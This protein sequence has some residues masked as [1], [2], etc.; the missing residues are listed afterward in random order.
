VADQNQTTNNSTSTG[1]PWDEPLDIPEET[2]KKEIVGSLEDN[3]APVANDSTTET[4]PVPFN[5]PEGVDEEKVGKKIPAEELTDKDKLVMPSQSVDSKPLDTKQN[6]DDSP[7]PTAVDP[8]GQPVD[9]GVI[10]RSEATKQSE[11]KIA[12]PDGLA[13]TNQGTPAQ[14]PAVDNIIKTSQ[15]IVET[16]PATPKDQSPASVS[17]IDKIKQNIATMP[18]LDQPTDSVKPADPETPTIEG[19]ANPTGLPTGEVRNKKQSIFS[20]IN[21][22]K[23]GKKQP[24]IPEAKSASTAPATPVVPTSQAPAT[25]PKTRKPI[26]IDFYKKPGFIGTVSVILIFIAVTFLTENGLVS[27]GFENVYGIVGLEK[28]WGGLPRSPESA[29]AHAFVNGQNNLEFKAKGEITM[30]VDKTINSP[31]TSPLVTVTDF[32]YLARDTEMGPRTKAILAQSNYYYNDDYYEYDNSDS[33]SSDSSSDTSSDS[34]SSST[35]DTTSSIYDTSSQEDYQSYS[36]DSSTIKEINAD[37][38]SLSSADGTKTDFTINKI[39]GKNSSISMI[40]NQNDL[41][42]NSSSDIKFNE[43]AEN[44]KWLDYSLTAL[45][46]KNVVND[47]FSL[48][49]DSGFSIIGRRI[50]NEK[51]GDQRCFRYQ[52]DSLEVSSSLEFLGIESEMVQKI[53]GDVWIGIK[54]KLIHKIDV[55]IIPSISSSA[56]R[57]DLEVE[58]YDYGSSNNIEIPRLDNKIAVTAGGELEESEGATAKEEAVEEEVT[59]TESS[60]DILRK[61][62]LASIKS[63]LLEYSSD[64]GYYPVSSSWS[65]INQA[66]SQVASKLVPEYLAS[67][68]TDPKSAEG[69]Y[70]GYKS[71]GKTFTLSARFENLN[72]SEISQ[73]GDIWLHYVYSSK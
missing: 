24:A 69:F 44:N 1:S 9:S 48:K 38:E 67:I 39:T 16:P 54:D 5:I 40:T 46:S 65:N 29:L 21:I 18:N 42:I 43:K 72:D 53:S 14:K 4:K 50:A 8:S 26:K 34:T 64:N 61:T 60:R 10:A 25:P 12:T 51:I 58:F 45:D 66:S 11:E 13:M 32:V 2:D 27:L 57:I 59:A 52:I 22:F 49:T 33:T 62:D 30:T 68:P 15:P 35:E 70:Y 6:R 41:Y 7:P 3:P 55:T 36:T 63:A 37:F 56:S 23:R 71:D 28:L 20:K 17:D 73:F 19:V 31:I 47:I